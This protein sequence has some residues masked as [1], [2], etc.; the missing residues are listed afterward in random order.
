MNSNTAIMPT[1]MFSIIPYS[2]SQ[3]FVYRPHARKN[4]I[5]IPMKIKSFINLSSACL[6]VVGLDN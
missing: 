2:F 6:G 3:N 5:T 1:M 4:A